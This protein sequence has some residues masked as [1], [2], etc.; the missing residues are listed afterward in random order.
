MWNKVD[1]SEFNLVNNGFY[2]EVGNRY[3]FINGAT[4]WVAVPMSIEEWEEVC[5]FLVSRPDQ[6]YTEVR[7]KSRTINVR[8]SYTGEI[9]LIFKVHPYYIYVIRPTH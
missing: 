9:Y 3:G 5:L 2:Y 7:K 6:L 8:F 1:K 4:A